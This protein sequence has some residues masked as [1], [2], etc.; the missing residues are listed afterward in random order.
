MDWIYGL[1]LDAE[2]T[3]SGAAGQNPAR[4]S[5]G[6][7]GQDAGAAEHDAAAGPADFDT[8]AHREGSDV[9][10]GGAEHDIAA[11]EASVIR[12][13]EAAAAAARS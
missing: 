4:S 11:R 9:A 12:A 8:A 7:A 2:E 5:A 1:P 10:G 13:V 6:G 3:R